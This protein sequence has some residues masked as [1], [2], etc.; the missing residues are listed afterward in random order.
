M[1]HKDGS[2]SCEDCPSCPPGQTLSIECGKRILSSALIKCEPCK[3][4]MS[5]SSKHGTSVCTPCASCAKDQV[6]VQNCT[7]MWDLK[8]DKR[9][10]GKDRY[11][12]LINPK[13]RAV[14]GEYQPK[15]FWHRQ[16]D[17]YSLH[18]KRLRMMFSQYSPKLVVVN[19]CK[20]ILLLS[21]CDIQP[22]I[23]MHVVSISVLP[24]NLS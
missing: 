9:C 8:C 22:G 21:V 13:H 19:N 6:V 2:T 7:L 11:F 5:F 23:D 12:L 1:E 10:Y 4:G 18:K 24:E 14:I 3:L 17:I 20:V 16:S 15:C